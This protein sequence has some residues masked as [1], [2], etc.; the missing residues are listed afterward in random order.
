MRTLK[1]GLRTFLT[2]CPGGRWW[3]FL[4]DVARGLRAIPARAT[5]YSPFFLVF[6]QNPTLPLVPQLHAADEEELIAQGDANLE[7]LTGVWEALY[8]EVRERQGGYDEG[9]VQ[10]Y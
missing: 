1:Q 10:A 7:E 9:M 4:G 5:G 2:A 6:K 3:E 8:R